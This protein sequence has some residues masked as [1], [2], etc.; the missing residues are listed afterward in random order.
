MIDAETVMLRQGLIL[1]RRL[2]KPLL[3]KLNMVARVSTM[4]RDM[5]EHLEIT[6]NVFYH[7]SDSRP[8]S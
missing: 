2:V 1:R 5:I 8:F 3:K 6:L 7:A 4:Q